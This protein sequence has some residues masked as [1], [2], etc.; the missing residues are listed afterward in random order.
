MRL[1]VKFVPPLF[2]LMFGFALVLLAQSYEREH[3]RLAADPRPSLATVIEKR[4][5]TTPRNDKSNGDLYRYMVRYKFTPEG[6]K[7][8]E[9]TAAFEQDAF[10]E[11]KEGDT[12]K[13]SYLAGEPT[14]HAFEASGVLVSGS[15]QYTT[16]ADTT[17]MWI[18]SALAALAVL[19]VL[20][21]PRLA[22]RRNA[23]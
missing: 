2:F 18:A 20:I 12:L 5:L 17:F 1:T 19:W 21:V 16:N 9:N 7:E 22:A 3:A 10:D 11:L 4:T 13:L 6:G 8:I 23:P 14:L 15:T